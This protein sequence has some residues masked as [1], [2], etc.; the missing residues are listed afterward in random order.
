M[1]RFAI[2]GHDHPAPHWDLFF[3]DGPVLRSWRLLGDLA[4]GI[5]VPA[6]ATADHR[7]LYLD[8]EGPV[9]GGRGQ[10]TR[11]DAGTFE[12]QSHTSDCSIVRLSGQRFVGRLTLETRGTGCSCR[13]DP[14]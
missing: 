11:V 5:A 13:F 8:Y 9:S 4:P 1:P 14:D 12:W 6:E 3:E 10:V 7:L 2:L